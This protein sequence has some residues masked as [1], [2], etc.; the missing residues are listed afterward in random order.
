MHVPCNYQVSLFPSEISKIAVTSSDHTPHKRYF[1][2]GQL[3]FSFKLI[4]LGE[5]KTAESSE[6]KGLNLSW[7]LNEIKLVVSQKKAGNKR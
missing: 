2:K 6:R 7:K 3:E 1:Y 5:A 4:Q